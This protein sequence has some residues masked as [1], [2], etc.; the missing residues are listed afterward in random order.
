LYAS[1]ITVT[2]QAVATE[3]PNGRYI[4]FPM[5]TSPQNVGKLN[6]LLNVIRRKNVIKKVP[7]KINPYFLISDLNFVESMFL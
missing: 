6:L 2:K 4:Y 7:M 3:L 1:I 5:W